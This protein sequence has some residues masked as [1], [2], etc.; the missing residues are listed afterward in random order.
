[1]ARSDTEDT[2]NMLHDGEVELVTKAEVDEDEHDDDGGDGDEFEVE[3]TVN[4]NRYKKLFLIRITIR[5]LVVSSMVIV[6][7][8]LKLNV[9]QYLMEFLN[10]ISRTFGS[11][12]S[13][14][15]FCVVFS[16]W[17]SV[18]PMGYLPTV[19]CGVLLEWYLAPFVAFISINIGSLINVLLIRFVIIPNKTRCGIKQILR[20]CCGKKMGQLSL[21]KKLFAA[22]AD[23]VR[24]VILLRLPYLNNGIINY[25]FSLQLESL[26]IKQNVIG[27]AIG[28]I[29]GSIIFSV[30]GTEIKSLTEIVANKGFHD[31]LQMVLF[32]VVLVVCIACYVAIAVKVKALIKRG[33]AIANEE[34]VIHQIQGHHIKDR[35]SLIV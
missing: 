9:H 27:N 16:V 15:L 10:F 30:F 6:A 22:S 17:T 14:V 5:V 31:T 3:Q 12:W 7:V 18:S 20:C 35:A 32:V 2:T 4:T 25:L 21:L 11:A 13:P 33:T 24:V 29:P 26:S 34:N 8:T 19:L 1:M 23:P 28:F